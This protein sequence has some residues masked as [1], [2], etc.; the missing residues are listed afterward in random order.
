MPGAYNIGISRG[1]GGKLSH[2]GA[3]LPNGVTFE[4]GGNNGGVMYGDGARG[5]ASFPLQFYLPIAGGDPSTGGGGAGG[6]PHAGGGGGGGSGG[7]GG[8]GGSGSGQSKQG[9]KMFS[10]LG[11]LADIG[12]G[13][14][15]E[16]FLPPG[17]SDPTQWPNVKSAAAALNSLGW[18]IG[19]IP[20][21]GNKTAKGI[22]NA[23][24]GGITGS[25]S[26]MVSGI[27]SAT[28]TP[29]GTLAPTPTA[30]QFAPGQPGVGTGPLPGPAPG[31][32]TTVN[33]GQVNEPTQSII[34]AANRQTASDQNTQL[35]SRRWV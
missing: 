16:T 20:G 2:M 6:T 27:E 29:F 1:G 8:T 17:F 26:S 9:E 33:I 13:G 12:F 30:A 10:D 15:K 18:F 28:P 3:T 31:N 4:A 23:V 24:A 34:T 35:G 19:G 7:G 32:G 21:Q 22:L 11:E 14:I 5:A 25:G